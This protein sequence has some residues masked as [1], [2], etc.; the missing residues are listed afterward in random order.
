MLCLILTFSTASIAQKYKGDSWAKVNAE[1][2]GTLACV[3]YETPG[4]IYKDP[5]SGQ[6][7]GVCADI[8]SDFKDFVKNKYGKEITIRYVGQEQI[9][10]NFLNESLKSPHV[11]GVA[12]VSITTERKKA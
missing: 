12:N 4:L 3:Y 6:M 10:T 11:L 1:G 8:L 7:K 2:A 9:F 5:S